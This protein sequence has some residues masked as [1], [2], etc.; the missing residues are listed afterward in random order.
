VTLLIAAAIYLAVMGA[1]SASIRRETQRF[2]RRYS[3]GKSQ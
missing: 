2:H 3:R 1:L